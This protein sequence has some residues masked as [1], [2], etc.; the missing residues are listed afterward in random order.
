MKIHWSL[1]KAPEYTG[2]KPVTTLKFNCDFSECPHIVCFSIPDYQPLN[3][4]LQAPTQS[5]PL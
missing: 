5:L 1:H 2:S 3:T 4:I